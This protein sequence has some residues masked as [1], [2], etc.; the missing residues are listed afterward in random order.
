MSHMVKG[1]VRIS[2]AMSL[3]V[4]IDYLLI[5]HV[6][7]DRTSEGVRPG[8]SV[9]FA[10]RTVQA[11]GQQPG[12]ITS[13]AVDANLS[14]L[15]GLPLHILPAAETTTF[16]NLYTANGR[17]QL[18]HGRAAWLTADIWPADWAV[19]AI[20]HLAPIA[21]EVDPDWASR[22]PD[23]LLGLTPQGWL[24]GWNGKG[25]VF[26]RDW[27][28][29]SRVLP[30]ATA[31]V[32]SEEDLLNPNQLEQFRQQSR[33]L[34]V[35]A[36]AQGCQVYCAG[37]ERHFAPPTVNQVDPTG[38]GDIFAAAFFLRLAQ[39]ENPWQAAEFA[40]WIAALSV[41]ADGLAAK[42]EVLQAGL[43]A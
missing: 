27:P 14:L 16:E 1:C 30:L 23:S 26:P 19:P 36:G 32:V 34:V 41:T 2:A 25:R 15:T 18:L 29:A 5:G 11:L 22:F 39:T 7:H 31:V 33:L 10:S 17:Q 3:S 37:E 13:A 20:V 24:R 21:D 40:N 12:I 42:I 6:S 9:T 28:D 8:G 43:S 35:T 4:Q 38:A